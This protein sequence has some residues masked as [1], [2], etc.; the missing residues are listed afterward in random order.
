MSQVLDLLSLQALD[1]E[2]AALRAA[3]A[4]VERR[5]QGDPELLDARRALAA[6]ETRLAAA[7]K[8]QRRIEGEVESLSDKIAHEEKRL[9]DGSV[10]SPKELTNLQHEVELLKGH[11]GRFEDQL[12]E[13][14][15]AAEGADRERRTAVQ[16]A[17]RLEL[18]WQ[19]AQDQLRHE[20]RRLEDAIARAD[21]RRDVQKK[22]IN[23][24][25]LH[26][27]EDLR[28]R[29]GGMAVARI[30]GSLCSGCRVTIPDMLRRRAMSPTELAQCPNCERIISL[31]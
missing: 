2:A 24:R 8:D 1:D 19:Q 23:P 18:R 27:Y 25:A 3:L 16:S 7:R 29:K 26:L 31:G 12:I 11:R 4:D 9:Y 15:D 20:V 13:V 22:G 14:L 30:S 5:L 17:G 10:H 21:A 6:I 28:K